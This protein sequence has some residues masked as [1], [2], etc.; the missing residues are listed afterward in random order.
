MPKPTLEYPIYEKLRQY[1]SKEALLKKMKTQM[2]RVLKDRTCFARTQRREYK[3]RL[4]M[5]K[6]AVIVRT[7]LNTQTKPTEQTNMLIHSTPLDAS[8]M[9]LL[10]RVGHSTYQLMMERYNMPSLLESPPT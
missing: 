6:L 4:L 1:S 5:G 10:S 2:R 8:T 3:L 7:E 9:Q